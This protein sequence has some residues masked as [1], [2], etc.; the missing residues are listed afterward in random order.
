MIRLVAFD[1]DGTLIGPDLSLSSRV[2]RALDAARACD[3]HVTVATGRMFGATVAIARQLQ[4][5]TPLI[6][7]QGGWIQALTDPEPRY[8]A[9]L[10]QEIAAEVLDLAAERRWHTVL[11]ADGDFYLQQLRYPQ[12][13]Y[14]LLLGEDLKEVPA[15]EPVLAAHTPDKILLVVDP[16]EIPAI[17]AQLRDCVAGRAEVVRSHELFVEVVPQRVDK[18][19]GLAWL[20]AHLGIPREEVLAVGDHEN[21]L[22]M[23]QWAGV[24]VAMGNAVPVVQAAA[25][26]IAPPLAADGAAVALERFVLQEIG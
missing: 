22:A 5:T 7:Y 19:A 12:H 23:I 18:G 14:A 25:D 16:E 24:G 15:W 3:V 17:A 21:D 26:W 11:Y 9:S 10:P 20:A 2:R 1:L 13:F 4:L 6:C 8:R